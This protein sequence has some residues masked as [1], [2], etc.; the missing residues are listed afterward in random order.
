MTYYLLIIIVVYGLFMLIK[1]AR[2]K[3]LKKFIISVLLLCIPVI[4]AVSSNFGK[5]WSIAE[6]SKY[7]IRGPSELSA[8]DPE[9]NG[10]DKEY[11]FQYSN[12]IFE[13]LMLLVPNIMGGASQQKLDRSSHLA[14]ALERN[15][16]SRKQ[17]EDQLKAVPTYWGKLPV[18]APYYAGIIIF[19]LFVFSMFTT[20]TYLKRWGLTLFILAVVLSWGSNF[21]LLNYFLYDYLPGYNKFRSVTFTITM[22]FIILPL[23]GLVGLEDLFRNTGDKRY[24]KLFKYAVYITGGVLIIALFYSWTGSFRGAIDERLG[25]LPGW[26]LNALR[27][28][29]ARLLRLDV[30]RN[31]VFLSLFLLT[32]WGLWKQKLNLQFAYI[33]IITLIGLDIT[34]VSSRY[35]SEDS[36]IRNSRNEI[37]TPTAADQKILNDTD[38]SFRVLNL[39][40]PFNEARTSYFHHSIG[41]YHGAKIRRYQ[42]LIENHISKEINRFIERYQQ[43]APAFQDLPVLKMLNAR[44]FYAGSEAQGVFRNPYASGNAWFVQNII[45]V[46]SPDEEIAA[47]GTLNPDSSCVLDATKFNTAKNRYPEGGTIRLTEYR[48]DYLK[49]ETS[50]N[51]EGF[52]VFSEV[53]YPEGWSASINGESAEIQRVNYILRALDVPEGNNIIEFRFKPAAYYVG[54]KI[55]MIGSLLTLLVFAACVGLHIKSSR[56]VMNEKE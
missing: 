55:S 3:T 23:L 30:I 34:L 52:A 51:H 21:K 32:L 16:L 10:L 11:L 43:G 8:Q 6:Y 42:D 9:N 56:E 14:K 25:N 33:I 44:Y 45:V 46:N 47:L 15:G 19:F 5:I 29:R 4:L 31:M 27:S 2:E 13:P 26:Y 39:Q 12:G 20:D 1:A 41:G 22:A 36:Y 38:L 18:T 49:Y 24:R 50:N 54:N 37:L 28:D 40:N 48:P 17:V 7:S 53:F 35:L